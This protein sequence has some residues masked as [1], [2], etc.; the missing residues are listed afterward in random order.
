[1][2]RPVDRK[3]SGE[4]A[5]DSDLQTLVR[6]LYSFAQT[7][8]HQ[9]SENDLSDRELFRALFLRAKAALAKHDR[10]LA[11]EL[12][13]PTPTIERWA[14]GVTSPHSIF[15]RAYLR[16]LAGVGQKRLTA[17]YSCAL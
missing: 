16:T 7:D 13:V 11:H 10:E 1:V 4:G 15:R 3:P 5:T 14:T 17:H 2:A 6:D 12:V 8:W 9:G